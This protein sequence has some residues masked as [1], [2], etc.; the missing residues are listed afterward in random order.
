M[1]AAAV[2]VRR[3]VLSSE[4]PLVHLTSIALT[5]LLDEDNFKSYDTEK[6]HKL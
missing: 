2:A 3:E 6:N 4:E 1:P 5:C